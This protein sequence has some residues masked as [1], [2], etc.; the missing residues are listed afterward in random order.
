LNEQ[1][2]TNIHPQGLG[3]RSHH[4][5]YVLYTSGSTGDPK[6]VMIE[7]AS[8]VNL[9]LSTQK[10]CG[11]VSQDGVLLFSTINFDPS[12]ANIFS[13]LC[14]GCRLILRSEDWLQS[15]DQFWERCASSNVTI[16]DLPTA[17]WHELAK[18]PRLVPAPCVRR[19]HIGGEKVNPAMVTEW[20]RK[21]SAGIRLLNVYGPTEATADATCAELFAGVVSHIGKP[22]AN[23]SLYV[24]HG[25]ATLAPLGAPGEL[26]I[27]GAGLAR[28]YLNRPDLTADRFVAN[29]YYDRDDASSSKRLYKTGDL[30]RYLADGNLEYIGRTDE[31]VKIRGF[32]IELGEIESQLTQH[33][34]VA[35]AV[36]LARED[37]PG[38]NRLVAYVTAKDGCRDN[39][40]LV[41]RLRDYLEERLPEYMVP[42]LFMI[43]PEIPLMPNGKVA[44][45]ALP[46]PDMSRPRSECVTPRTETE[47]VLVAI[48]AGLLHL[49]PHEISTTA[50]FFDLGGHSLL[51]VRLSS[52]ISEQFGVQPTTK[53]LFELTNIVQ[54]GSFIDGVVELNLISQHF[55]SMPSEGVTE[56][57][58]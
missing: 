31:Q 53:K 47:R 18:D 46:R 2:A 12:V 54:I 19:I 52:R 38:E 29:P 41:G 10:R 32:R 5:A 50:D 11:L 56:V 21:V 33:V 7:H 36:V 55:E 8:V 28:G 20:C 25:E 3:L 16:L 27:G 26:Y 22:I 40:D 58:I 37:V 9:T 43:V 24:M 17:Y 48:W 42:A 6:G 34:E 30:V 23:V 13:A 1:S 57:E 35:S 44:K 4:L 49:E 39:P 14:S 15:T 45:K 51:L